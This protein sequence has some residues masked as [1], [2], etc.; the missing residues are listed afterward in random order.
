MASRGRR[1]SRL[2]PDGKAPGS[3]PRAASVRADWETATQALLDSL[4]RDYE[5]LTSS[6]VEFDRQFRAALSRRL[7]EALNNEVVAMPCTT[8]DNKRAVARWVNAQLRRF[9][10]ALVCPKTKRPAVLLADPSG[11]PGTGRFQFQS[12]TPDGEKVRAHSS[13]TLPR[14]VLTAANRK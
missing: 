2:E 14:L 5:R 12:E 8:Y 11:V 4:P 7:E 10:L 9:G 3:Q 13:A 6:F 1:R